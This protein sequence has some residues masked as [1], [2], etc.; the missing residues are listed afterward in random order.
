MA[1]H[2][3]SLD[4]PV[5]PSWWRPLELLAAEAAGV[6]GL[7]PVDPDDFLYV[8]WVERDHLPRLH[9][10]RNLLSC[11]HLNVDALGQVWR[12]VR[13]TRDGAED[14]ARLEGMADALAQA[15][16][17][18]ADRLAVRTRRGPRSLGATVGH[19]PDA[20]GDNLDTASPDAAGHHV[21][22]AGPHA[23]DA[24]L[25]TAGPDAEDTHLDTA[26]PEAEGAHLDRAAPD[27][28]SAQ[29]DTA[30]SDGSA[31]RVKS[32]WA[33]RQPAAS[34]GMPGTA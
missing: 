21:D 29:L 24:H 1:A 11:R 25:D 31:D 3:L 33:R 14:Y 5:D 9:V 6:P 19:G 32:R 23:E 7:P 10:Y 12:Y 16:L 4:E 17:D 2:W 28:D 26:G 34:S 18:R 30:R 27:A 13:R 8:A 20:S 15:E 22:T